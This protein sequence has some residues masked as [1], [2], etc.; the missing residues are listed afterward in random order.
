MT[1]SNRQFSDVCLGHALCGSLPMLISIVGLSLV[2]CGGSPKTTPPVTGQSNFTS[3]PASSQ[4]NSNGRAFD[5]ASPQSASVANTASTGSSTSTPRTVEE[6]DLYRLDGDRLYYLNAYRGLMVFDI[7][8]VDAP[9]LLGR[10][11]IY[12]SPI[13]MLVRNGVATIVVSDWYGTD[14][15]GT[16]FYGSIV[17]G[18]D[19][20]DPTHMKVLGDAVLGGWVRDTRVV[21]DVLYAVTEQ[22]SWDPVWYGGGIAVSN[23]ASGSSAS[24]VAAVTS[25]SG[26]SVAVTSV[27]F[28]N[29]N[30]QQ[31]DRYQ[32]PGQG[33]VF[34]VTS[35][36]IMLASSETTT[37]PQY[38]YQTPTGRTQLMY[39]DIS[40]PAGAIKQRGSQMIDGT[41]Q[42]WGADNG[43]WNIDFADGKTAHAVGCV[44]Q[45]C[46]ANSNLILSTVDFSNPD[47]PVA[48]SALNIASSSYSPTARFDG[49]RMYLAPASSCYYGSSSANQSIPVQI[50]DLSDPSTPKFAGAADISG[51][52]WLFMPN[53]S[54]LF[55]LGSLCN[56]TGDYYRSSVSLNYLDVTNASTPSLIGTASFGQGWSWTPAADTFKAFT[57]N[58]AM[59]LVVLPFS[60]WD[61][62]SYQYNNGLQLI[63]FTAS[64]INT[65][66]AAMS[67]GWVERGIFAKNRLVSLSDLALTVVDFTDHA[68]P[69]VVTEMTLARNVVDVKP[70][71]DTVAELS[72][73]F[74]DNDQKHSTLRVLPTA[75]AEELVSDATLAEVEID[76]YNSSV[77]HN[78][79]LSYVI[80]NIQKEVD[81]SVSGS[82]AS[83]SPVPAGTDSADA[84]ATSTCYNWTQEI[85][86]VDRSNGTAVKRGKIDM[87]SVGGYWYGGWG[88]Y[89]CDMYSWYYGADVVQ[90]GN[91]ALAFKRWLPQY[92]SDGT[93]L[94]AATALYVVDLANPDQPTLAST[95]I[96]SDL[97]AWWGNMRA[98]QDKLYTGH[99]EWEQQPGYD[100]QTYDPG[101]VRYY[102]DQIDLSDRAHPRIAAKINVP[103]I[104]VGADQTDPSIVYTMDYQWTN[105]QVTNLFDVLKLSGD[106]AYLQASVAVPGWVGNTFVQ[107]SMAYFSVENYDSDSGSTSMSLYQIDVTDPN[108]PTPSVST[109]AQGWGWL[110]G[111]QGDRAFVTSGW[112]NVGIDVFR[113]QPGQAP[114]FDQFIRVRGWWTNSLARQD[115]Q[116]FLASGY[117]GTQMVN[118]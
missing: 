19:A 41:V 67:R 91:D 116:L 60:G 31:V 75:Q 118:L 107:G 109:P 87:P 117:W 103:G 6:T 30:V 86:V 10:S 48:K 59:G 29:G 44:G 18:I 77:F 13:E 81:C 71:G 2:G 64:S 53:G 54:R 45:Y 35:S 100:G 7:T 83:N 20:T 14:S 76:G 55:A 65:A 52:V 27:D 25:S 115:N 21:G 69:K 1:I 8:N 78:G 51:Q 89:G 32:V 17:R 68:N 101:I 112:G 49:T 95:T 106:Q 99:Y 80:S 11:P 66:G 40:D 63:E 70:R 97:N 111:V 26:A 72:S 93:Y 43:R 57:E 46:N 3:R 88:W 102:L 110:L 24:G 79:D 36:S 23:T 98:V 9:K 113:L 38:G 94:D 108:H 73:D 114:V 12:G 56:S 42:G 82:T 15:N 90:V 84:S 22:Y 74:W 96:T 33:G 62:T 58:D 104:L 105:N 85:Q 47:A 5:V 61:S 92:A 16:P 4:N 39:L 37:D 28:A 50:Y 34:N